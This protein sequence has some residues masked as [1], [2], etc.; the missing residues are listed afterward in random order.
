MEDTLGDVYK[1]QHLFIDFRQIA[2][3]LTIDFQCLADWDIQM[4]IRDRISS[5]DGDL[6][7]TVPP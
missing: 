2:D 7:M 6:I 3:R 4:C 5:T 1:R